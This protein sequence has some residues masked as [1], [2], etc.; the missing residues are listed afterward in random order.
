[1]ARRGQRLLLRRSDAAGYDVR[2]D[3]QTLDLAPWLDQEGVDEERE[4]DI[5]P[6]A[7]FHLSL[8]AERLIVRGSRCATLLPIW[9]AARMAGVRP[10]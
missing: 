9:C 2:I 4:A 10:T 5:E 6:D 7:P 1:M 3:A 8:Q